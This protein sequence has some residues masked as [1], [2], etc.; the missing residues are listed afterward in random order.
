MFLSINGCLAD[1]KFIYLLSL[2]SGLIPLILLLKEAFAN[3]K[4]I[5]PISWILFFNSYVIKD[6]FLDNSVK[7]F[8]ISIAYSALKLFNSLFNSKTDKGSIKTVEPLEEI[9]WTKPFICPLYSSFTG[10][11]YLS[12]FIVTILSCRNLE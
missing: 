4:S 8:E 1:I 7:I 5:S 11:T 2:I 3:I 6:S 12:F 10:I 9:S